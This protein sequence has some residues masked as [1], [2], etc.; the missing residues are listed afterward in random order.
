MDSFG[1]ALHNLGIKK[2]DTVAILLPNSFQ[3]VIAFYGAV[4]IGAIAT[5]I[6]PTYMPL[7]VLHHINLTNAKCLVCLDALYEELV[8]PIIEKTNIEFIIN[9]NVVDLCTGLPGIKKVLGKLIGKIPK[10]KI[11]FKRTYNFLELLKTTPHIPDVNIDPMNDTCTYIM[12][13]GT[14]GVPQGAVLTHF[15]VV[16]NAIQCQ[17]WFGG[18]EPGVGDLGVLPLF[19]SFGLTAVMN[20]SIALGG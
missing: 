1:T 10:G 8:E 13:G 12:T 7:E 6:N 4:K 5:G 19:H 3:Y 2:G 18:E 20:A 15:N 9:T 11:T 16:S 14:T 17:L